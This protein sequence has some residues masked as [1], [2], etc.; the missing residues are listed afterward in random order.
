V[1]VLRFAKVWRWIRDNVTR[2]PERDNKPV[3]RV[4]ELR[5]KKRLFEVAKSP[6]RTTAMPLH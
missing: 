2:L 3:A 5:E 1:R 4:L 6:N